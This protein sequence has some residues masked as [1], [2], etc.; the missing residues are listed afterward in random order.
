MS[1]A[2]K[3]DDEKVRLDLLPPEALWGTAEVLTFGA[4]KY[5]AHNWRKGL[6]YS[7]VYG[8]MLRHITKWWEGEDLDPES[9]ISHLHHS[10]CCIAFLQTFVETE[11][12]EL[13]D[14]PKFTSHIVSSTTY[15]T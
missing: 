9:G 12:T 1:K 2:E 7:R 13:D 3:F 14:R 6:N 4:K 10:A 11:R 8:A 15:P 5:A